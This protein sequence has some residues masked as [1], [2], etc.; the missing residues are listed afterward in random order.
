VITVSYDQI[1]TA[2]ALLCA[3]HGDEKRHI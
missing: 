1:K 3:F 2:T